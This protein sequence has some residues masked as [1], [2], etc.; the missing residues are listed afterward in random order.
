VTHASPPTS[1]R[2]HRRSALGTVR[3]GP[4]LRLDGM[5]VLACRRAGRRRPARGRTHPHLVDR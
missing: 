4:F 2:R 1:T 5:G 3:A